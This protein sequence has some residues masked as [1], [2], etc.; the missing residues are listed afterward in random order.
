M[1]TIGTNSEDLIL[2]ADGSGSDIKFK[3]NGSEVA[4]ISDG[5]VVTA[6][7]FAGSGASLTGITAN[8]PSSADG[9]ALGSAS[10][11]WS[12]LYLADGGR[13]LFGNDQDVELTHDADKGLI[14]K[15]TA[16]ADDKPVYLTLASGETELADDEVIGKIQFLTPDE[17]SGG[18]SQLVSAAIQAVAEGSYT[19][20]WNQGRLEFMTGS[21]EA[22]TTKMTITSDGRGK[23]KF[24][25]H[26]WATWNGSGNV[27][28]DSFNVSSINDN[29]SGDDTLTFANAMNNNKVIMAACSGDVDDHVGW[30]SYSSYPPTT[31]TVRFGTQNNAGSYANREGTTLVFFGDS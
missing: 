15:H 16:T 5:G 29:S 11:E 27:L 28:T 20:A 22:A 31:T 3:S 13:V 14:I 8:V 1:S 4:S 30:R 23:S 18:D 9:Q 17:A 24:T 2:N 25:A 21:S 19:A 10:L 26:A 6:T 12:D 7:S